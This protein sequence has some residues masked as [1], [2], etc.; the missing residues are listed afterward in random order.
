[1]ISVAL[2]T[3]WSFTIRVQPLSSRVR[4]SIRASKA[5]LR[6]GNLSVHSVVWKHFRY[7]SKM[8]W[9]MQREHEEPD[10]SMVT[11]STGG[12]SDFS[13]TLILMKSPLISL[14]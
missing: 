11:R 6:M 14:A 10:Y 5:F 7:Y 4:T 3:A 8:D 1:M 13:A 2:S 12:V 9:E